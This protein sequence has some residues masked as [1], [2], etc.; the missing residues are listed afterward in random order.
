LRD[1]EKRRPRLYMGKGEEKED[2]ILLV[3]V[4]IRYEYS[5]FISRVFYK[6]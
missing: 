6:G 2:E 3:D 1:D 4:F 5:S